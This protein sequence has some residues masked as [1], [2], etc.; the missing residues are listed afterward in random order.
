[1]SGGL[2]P[3]LA[4]ACVALCTGTA[5]AATAARA[6]ST[7]DRIRR[8]CT[9]LGT[10]T[11]GGHPERAVELTF[12]RLVELAGRDNVLASLKAAAAGSAELK[13][14]GVACEQ[15]TQHS[16]AGGLDFAL[17]PTLARA[18]T[19]EGLVYLPQH[20]LAISPDRG[21]TWSFLFL[22]PGV[23]LEKLQPLLPDGIGDMHLPAA[24]KPFA[25]PTRPPAAA[26]AP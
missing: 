4:A 5:V 14:L 10:A 16:S 13:T 7:D 15:P 12:P 11:F 6:V 22:S 25:I 8:L 24:Q 2:R 20:Y 9:D 1:M 19:P 26:S 18:R 21:A 17:V 3:W 23:T